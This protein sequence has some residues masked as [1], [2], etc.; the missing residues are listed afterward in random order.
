MDNIDYY[1]SVGTSALDKFQ[2]HKLEI[3]CGT[4]V[5]LITNYIARRIYYSYARTHYPKSDNIF[6]HKLK[7]SI[8]VD[9]YKRL[10]DIDLIR[11]PGEKNNLNSFQRTQRVFRD[12][13]DMMRRDT[14][15]KLGGYN[16]F[17]TDRYYE[18]EQEQEQESQHKYDTRSQ[19]KRKT[20]RLD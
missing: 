13:L 9:I 7:E 19:R 11:S 16:L 20:M 4:A 12:Y 6:V 14:D 2:E 5:F 15:F 18:H 10:Y 1:L 17:V 3:T 8:L